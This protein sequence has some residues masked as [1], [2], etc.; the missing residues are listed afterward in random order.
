LFLR[1]D[2]PPPAAHRAVVP[3]IERIWAAVL[4]AIITRHNTRSGRYNNA[5]PQVRVSVISAEKLEPFIGRVPILSAVI[6][7]SPFYQHDQAYQRIGDIGTLRP[8]RWINGG[9]GARLPGT[10]H[11]GHG[12]TRPDG[13]F[14]LTGG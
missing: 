12:G 7:G 1:R 2:G 8:G 9:T 11:R 4:A 10:E 6:A 14:C 3:K 13:S 5:R